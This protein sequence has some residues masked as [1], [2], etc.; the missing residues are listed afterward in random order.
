MNEINLPDH[1]GWY[2]VLLEGWEIP[3]PC[4]YSVQGEYFLP[5]GMGDSSSTGVFTD[6]ITKVGPEIMVPEF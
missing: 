5:G 1:D 6:D 3:V 4:W 2:W